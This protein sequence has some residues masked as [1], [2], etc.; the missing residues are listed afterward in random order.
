MYYNC[1]SNTGCYNNPYP[2]IVVTQGRSQTSFAITIS[3]TSVSPL[4][5]CAL[6]S[7]RQHGQVQT[8]RPPPSCAQGHPRAVADPAP[9]APKHR[10]KQQDAIFFFLDHRAPPREWA[11]LVV[12]Q[13]NLELAAD[14]P[15]STPSPSGPAAMEST[16]PVRYSSPRS[17]KSKP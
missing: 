13:P 5:T 12:P 14:A 10:S 3:P 9:P 17:P 11:A 8:P 7:R 1:Y 6:A 2:L 15:P 4:L 16:T